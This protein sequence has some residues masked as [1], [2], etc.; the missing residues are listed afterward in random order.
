MGDEI[1][2]VEDFSPSEKSCDPITSGCDDFTVGFNVGDLV[3]LAR[4]EP[5][6]LGEDSF[7]EVRAKN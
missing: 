2:D 3:T 4:L 5:D 7:A 1:I 6:L